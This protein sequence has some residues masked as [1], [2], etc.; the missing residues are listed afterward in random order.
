M[1]DA[2][3]PV[4]QPQNSDQPAKQE[5]R[6]SS[7]RDRAMERMGSEN[8]SA[9]QAEEKVIGQTEAGPTDAHQPDE[10]YPDEELQSQDDVQ[11]T[12]DADTGVDDTNVEGVLGEQDITQLRNRAE[13]AETMVESMQTDYTRKTQKIAESRKELLSNLEQSQ[14]LSEIYAQRA[15][16]AVQRFS[17]V[18]WQQLQSTLDPQTYNARVAEYQQAVGQRD[19]EV[20][21]HEQ[22][23]KFV[24]E[25]IEQSNNDA[26]EI[27]RDV[28]RTTVPGWGNELYGTLREFATSVLDFTQV[29]F[30]Q[31]TDH[32]VIKLIHNSWKVSDTS[33]RVKGI[34]HKSQAMQPQGGPNRQQPRGSDGRFR[35]AQEKHL[36]NPG[37][38]DLTREAFRQRLQREHRK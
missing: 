9:V 33:K 10:G 30:D 38:R 17:G 32:R 5:S 23:K 35:E 18:N 16:Q 37:N 34:Q 25:Q 27:S 8:P 29:E 26:A 6:V 1:G 15:Q 7:F 3:Q 12:G 36:A 19:R 13:E 21:A 24:G 20:Q 28:L 2:T 11:P 14:K 22:I 31:I 4:T